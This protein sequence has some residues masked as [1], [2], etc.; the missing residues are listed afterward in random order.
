MEACHYG[1]RY[2]PGPQDKTL[3]HTFK[4]G[5]SP[6]ASVIMLLVTQAGAGGIGSTLPGI[7]N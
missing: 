6:G 2:S 4:L 3:S 7:E 1:F 5:M